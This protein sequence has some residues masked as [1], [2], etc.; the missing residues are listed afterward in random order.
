MWMREKFERFTKILRAGK[1]PETRRKKKPLGIIWSGACVAT[2]FDGEGTAL[3]SLVSAQRSE[4]AESLE[5]LPS[6]FKKQANSPQLSH[7]VACS[8]H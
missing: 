7:N 4:A 5:Q 8:D 3:L 6:L 2:N 1:P